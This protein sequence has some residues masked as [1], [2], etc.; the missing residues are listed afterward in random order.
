MVYMRTSDEKKDVTPYHRRRRCKSRPRENIT[1]LNIYEFLRSFDSM[2]DDTRRGREF[3]CKY[4][5]VDNEDEY[6]AI[7]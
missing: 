1:R 4:I 3:V 5:C 7:A 2:M 6:C